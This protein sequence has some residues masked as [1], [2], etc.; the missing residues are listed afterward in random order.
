MESLSQT[1][2]SDPKKDGNIRVILNLKPFNHDYVEK[3][4]FKMETLKSTINAMTRKFVIFRAVTLGM[5]FIVFLYE[6]QTGNYFAFFGKD[7]NISLHA[8]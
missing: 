1:Y 6:Y 5:L 3:I 4:H 2:L 8:W 7:R